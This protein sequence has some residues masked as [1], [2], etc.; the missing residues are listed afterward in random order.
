MSV[1]LGLISVW[2][3]ICFSSVSG[4]GRAGRPERGPPGGARASWPAG[5]EPLSPG[6]PGRSAR[7]S[8]RLRVAQVIQV[9][10]MALVCLRCRPARLPEGPETVSGRESPA[11]LGAIPVDLRPSPHPVRRVSRAAAARPPEPPGGPPESPRK[12]FSGPGLSLGGSGSRSPPALSPILGRRGATLRARCGPAGA[13]LDLTVP[14]KPP[15]VSSCPRGTG[16]RPGGTPR[17][18]ADLPDQLTQTR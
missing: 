2:T 1:C 13:R 7:R 14:R 12:L 10:F 8:R 11:G 6:D 15:N 3:R 16:R 4:R 17:G 9:T 5:P 18:P